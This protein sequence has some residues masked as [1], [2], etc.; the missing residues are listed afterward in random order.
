MKGII[1]TDRYIASKGYMKN[2][3][4]TPSGKISKE[5]LF[6]IIAEFSVDWIYW[7]NPDNTI[8]YVSPSCKYITGYRSEEF[9]KDP[10]LIFKLI[11][12]GDRERF[13]NHSFKVEKGNVFCSEEY[14]IITKYGERK[15]IVHT[16]QSV[17]DDSNIYLGRYVSNKDITE[18]KN[19]WCSNCSKEEIYNSVSIGNYQVYPDGRMKYVN[20]AIAQMLGFKFT[21]ELIGINMETKIL[22]DPEKRKKV[23]K[24]LNAI[25]SLKN[26]ESEWI[27]KDGSILYVKEKLNSVKD[28]KGN[29]IYYEGVVQN[30]TEMKQAEFSIKEVE[31]KAKKLEKLKAEF[32]ATISHE[33]RTPLNVILNLTQMLKSDLKKESCGELHENAGIIESESKRIQRTIDLILEMSQLVTGTYDYKSEIF[34]LYEDVL[35]KIYLE[36]KKVAEEKNIEFLLTDSTIDSGI[37]ADKY[38][39]YQ[40]FNQ[41]V[42]NAIKYT[43]T[44]KVEINLRV[45]SNNC[46]A[47]DVRDT[48]FGID[49]QYIP[50]LFTT[51]S[52]EDNSYS[53]MFEGTGLGLA[54]VKKYCDLNELAINVE[55]KKGNGSVFSVHF[56]KNF[57]SIK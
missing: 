17:F 11:D 46:I 53:R 49:E 40:I 32:L 24:I 12:P 48:G 15:W 47:V 20:E 38:S 9:I 44:G 41:L 13:K 26:V 35:K 19:M 34:D 3:S 54:I 33:I 1:K 7:I 39:V 28:S 56:P 43:R 22:L 4:L 50:Y 36:H 45:N 27:K 16:C 37:I 51:F 57:Q 55:S 10:S 21:S 6:K 18:L 14:K 8:D 2:N 52:Q 5:K 25:G 31:S 23:K 29:V 30:I 42:D